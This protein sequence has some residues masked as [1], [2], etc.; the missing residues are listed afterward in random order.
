MQ[1]S[2]KI[3]YLVRYFANGEMLL[4]LQEKPDQSSQPIKEQI[5]T[6]KANMSILG[7]RIHALNKLLSQKA[8]ETHLSKKHS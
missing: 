4:Q 2:E 6:I 8:R 5:A 1:S 3:D 7:T